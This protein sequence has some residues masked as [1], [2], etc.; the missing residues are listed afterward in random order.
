MQKLQAIRGMPDFLPKAVLDW[1][2]FEKKWQALIASYG[3]EEI[4]LPILESTALFKRSIGEV[5]DIVEKEMFTFND[6]DNASLSMRPEGTAGCVRAG[7]ENNLI[8]NQ[9]Q[10]LWYMGPMFRYEKPQKGRYRQFHQ[11]GVEAFGLEGPDVEVEHILMMTRF[12]RI[13]GISAAVSLEVNSLG[14]LETRR[15]YREKLVQYL[16]QYQND[17]DADS[18]RRLHTNP[19]RILDSKNPAMAAIIKG[20]PKCYDYLDAASKQHFEDFSQYLDKAGVHYKINPNL[21]RGLDYYNGTVYEWSTDQLGSQGTICAGGRYDGLV[22]Q[23]GGKP[24]FAVG[25]AVGIERVLLLQRELGVNHS[26]EIDAYL[27]H[28]GEEPSK[29]ALL[30]AEA[31]RDNYPELRMIVHCGGGNFKHQF[32]FADK[33]EAK[34]AFIL[35]EEELATDTI[36]VKFLREARDQLRISKTDISQFLTEYLGR[37]Q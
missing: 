8:Y 3:Y 14:T 15:H 37:K 24:T 10:R 35:G 30:F 31:L 23:L 19:L 5:T 29:R 27:V 17:L 18:Q 21:V 2:I 33:S 12:W 4:R 32:K 6:R 16:T 28:V 26:F 9:I 7:L 36:S 20:A 13:L 1:Q 25:F 34:I 22:E 11:V